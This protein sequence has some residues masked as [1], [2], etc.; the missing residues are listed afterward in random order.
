MKHLPQLL[1]VALIALIVWIVDL[2][3]VAL[4]AAGAVV[5]GAGLGAVGFYKIRGITSRKPTSKMMGADTSAASQAAN[6][7]APATRSTRGSPR[8]DADPP[9]VSKHPAAQSPA[10]I[11][12]READKPEPPVEKEADAAKRF[13][14]AQMPQRVPLSADLSLLVRI[15]ADADA[16]PE[17]NSKAL[18]DLEIGPHG[19]RVTVVVQASRD[20]AAVDALE[21]VIWVP[22]E[23]DSKPVR[24]GFRARSVGLHRVV[25]SAWV[26]GTF[27]AELALE[28]SVQDGAP[29]V[30]SPAQVV[31]VDALEA[32]P[33]E[34]TLQVGFDG[35]HYTFQ[36]LSEPCYFEPVLAEAVTARPTDAVERTL[37]MLR[38][39]AEG[40]TRY[41][42]G[43]AQ[44][45]IEQAGVGLWND[46][47]PEQ[48]KDQFWQLRKQISS[49][50]IA[51]A[52]GRDVIPWELLYPLAPDTD[53]GF[54]VQQFP[55]MRRV[56]GQQRFHSI[57]LGDTRYVLPPGSPKNAQNEIAAIQ[58]ILGP[59]TPA[60]DVVSD[61]ETLIA[62]IESQKAGLV[63]FAC[64]NTFRV[65]DGG[66]SI[67]MG[68]GAF[69]PMLLNKAVTRHTL[70]GRHPM[71]FVNAC[72]SAGAVPEYTRMMGWAEQFM[73]AGAGAFV[74]TLWA[75]RSET[76]SRFAEAFYGEITSGSPLGEAC[77]RARLTIDHSDPTWLAYSIY[78]DPDATAITN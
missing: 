47:V 15:S 59:S 14:V 50:S 30:D 5:G 70:S 63:H 65:D 76:A 4:I 39:M 68:G 49:F 28:V 45:W 9:A 34:V 42:P 29:Y 46:M 8:S 61:L 19:V 44:T 58:Q 40:S 23:G 56:F 57:T 64:H 25:V 67:S 7:S 31:P 69:T 66:S 72:R 18:G 1:I 33:G 27:L 54:L 11:I 48:I 32:K 77:H 20:L 53:E 17:A 74:G 26:G 73:A 38:S 21:Q 2:G 75:I 12:V 3:E 43:N 51:I 55:V 16:F 10:P 60:M 36:L 35:H 78:G 6:A 71:I 37:A 13:L 52:R 62:L 41:S 24:F 22:P